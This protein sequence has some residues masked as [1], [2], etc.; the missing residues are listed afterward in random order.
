MPLATTG[1][2]LA[3]RYRVVRRLGSGGMATVFLAEDERLSRLVAVKR[4]HGESSVEVVRRFQREARLGAALNHPNIVSVYD[5]ADDA[6]GGLIVMEYVEG[7][8]LR[9]EIASGPVPAERAIPVLRAVANALAHA[10]GHG[11]VHRDVK[12]ANVLIRHDGVTKL[13]DLGIATAAEQSKITQSGSV[14]GTAAYLAPERLEGAAGGPAADI[15]GLAVV[16]FEALSGRK[17]IEGA[18]PME[19]AH[20]VVSQP[21]PDLRDRLPGAPA[22]A[23]DALRRGLAKDP[24]ERPSDACELVDELATAF[25]PRRHRVAPVRAVGSRLQPAIPTT[26]A[27]RSVRPALLALAALV[28]AGGVLA[29]VLASGGGSDKRRG[30]S[31]PSAATQA[32]AAGARGAASSAG[33]SAGR[34]GGSAAVPPT[35]ATL[36][37]ASASSSSP[38]AAASTVTPTGTVQTFYGDAARH[39]Y[40]A[41]WA[42]GTARLH[43]QLQGYNSFAAGQSTLRS[44]SFPVLRTTR[45]TPTSATVQ[46]HSIATHV[47]RTDRCA[48]TV[49]LL[50][51]RGGWMV[52]ALHIA[53][54]TSG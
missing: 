26:R 42:L 54:C 41:A 31:A 29:A 2:L 3:D 19:V 8:T 4:V 16:A 32:K 45:L 52:D 49:D 35:A 53:S 12:P 22:A 13:A 17:P 21:V 37:P 46:L 25:E 48:G 33:R 40:A 27:R 39:S 1:R 50:R 28:V 9:D 14:L 15:Y 24:E 18:T 34:S 11:V 30:A 38:A 36:P 44:I 51:T 47:N 43:A 10:H 6:E 20:R 7:H 23:A 5:I